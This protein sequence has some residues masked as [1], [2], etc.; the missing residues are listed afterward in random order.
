M[1]DRG[2]ADR[3]VYAV[4]SALMVVF[5]LGVVKRFQQSVGFLR[6]WTTGCFHAGNRTVWLRGSTS[7]ERHTDGYGVDD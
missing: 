2:V 7:G 5:L 4:R 6:A 3:L 1:I